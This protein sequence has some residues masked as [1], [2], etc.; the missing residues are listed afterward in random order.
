MQHCAVY[1]YL[2]ACPS[3]AS[4]AG[5]TPQVLQASVALLE[6]LLL[7]TLQTAV[8]CTPQPGLV[9][10]GWN[11]AAGHCLLV[12][13][14]LGLCFP[15]TGINMALTATLADTDSSQFW[16]RSTSRYI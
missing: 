8:F 13:L 9:R 11:L 7:C 3:F 4:Y 1:T 15:Q 12:T 5:I 6:E 14:L 10:I 2:I 16:G